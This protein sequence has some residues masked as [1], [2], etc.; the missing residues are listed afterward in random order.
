MSVQISKRLLT[1]SEYHKMAEAGILNEDD[2]VELIHG[3]IIEMSPIGSRHSGHVK[4][5]LKL[6]VQLLD[7]KATI[8]VQDPIVI[9]DFS[10]P[11]PDLS[12][13]EF[14]EDFYEKEHP[15][16]HQVFLIIEVADSSLYYDR[17]TKLPIYAEAGIP[18]CWIVN[19]E[20]EQIEIH[21][22]PSQGDYLFKET[23]KRNGTIF[24]ER[25][26]LTIKASMILG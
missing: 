1:V 16:P 8:G 19:I 3:E 24:W 6:L 4:R 10:E 12:I 2:R 18:E 23:V 5:I 20:D 7:D 14:R 22:T 26:D 13:L 17:T 11:E 9:D 21:K 25:F 15:R